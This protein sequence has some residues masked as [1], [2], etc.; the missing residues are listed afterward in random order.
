MNIS[1]LILFLASIGGLVAVSLMESPVERIDPISNAEILVEKAKM[2]HGSLVK[3]VQDLEYKVR[4][5]ENRRTY[6]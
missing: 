1:F 5:L 4:D 2:E 6:R 3:R